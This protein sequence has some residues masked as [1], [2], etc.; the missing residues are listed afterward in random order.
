[1]GAAASDARPKAFRK[2][3]SVVFDARP[4]A[5]QTDPVTIKPIDF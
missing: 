5:D 1:M 3:G 2:M 4:K